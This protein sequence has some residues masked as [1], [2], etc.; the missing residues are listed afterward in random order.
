MSLHVH[1]E[2]RH[3]H[4]HPVYIRVVYYI[5]IISVIGLIATIFE[6]QFTAF[7]PYEVLSSFDRIPLSHFFLYALFTVVRLTIAFSVSLSIAFIIVRLAMSNKNIE[8]YL[9]PVFD[10]LQSIPVLA[11]FPFIIIVF[12]RLQMPEIAAQIVLWV[13]ML[14]PLLFGAIGGIHQIPEDILYAADIYGAKGGDKF[15]KVILPAIFPALVTGAVLSFGSGWN[16]I[17]ISEFI[18]YGRTQISLHGLG[19]IMGTSAGNDIG[20]FLI[21]LIIMI[22]IIV[23]MNRLIWKR[24]SDYSARYKFD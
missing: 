16:V 8:N 20:V 6:T 2:Q 4:K 15:F 13:A 12:A 10:I 22:S 11:F 24:L 19:N 18:N 14:W 3:L 7:F 23:L 17:I 9:M 21:A 5:F 1:N